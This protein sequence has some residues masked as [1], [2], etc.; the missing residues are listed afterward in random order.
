MDQIFSLEFFYSQPKPPTVDATSQN[1]LYI[2]VV[3]ND[4]HAK[5]KILLY[6]L[7]FYAMYI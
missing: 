5:K 6:F 7:V 1:K 2:N 4:E 3:S